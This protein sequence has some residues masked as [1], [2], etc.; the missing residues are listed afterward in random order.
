MADEKNKPAGGDVETKPEGA[1]EGAKVP[2]AKDADK[3]AAKGEKKPATRRPVAKKPAPS[4]RKVSE[5]PDEATFVRAQARFVRSSPRKSRLVVDHIRGKK[6]E[7]A[8][9]TLQFMA[10]HV[11]RD[12]LKVLNSAVANAEHNHDLDADDLTVAIAYVDEGPTLKRWRPRAKGRATQILKRTSH[13]TIVVSDGT[14][15]QISEVSSRKAA[16]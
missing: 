12:V 3:P 13:I 16:A 2:V 14:A 5:A 6:I 11:A 8:R 9:V 15:K 4:R 7:E 1:K 10:R